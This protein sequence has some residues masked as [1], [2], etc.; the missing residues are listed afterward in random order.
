LS[1]SDCRP[2]FPHKK[3]PSSYSYF[4]VSLVANSIDIGEQMEGRFRE[5]GSVLIRGRLLSSLV[6]SRTVVN[7]KG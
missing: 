5:A 7:N 2:S 1:V 6:S 4:S 3:Q